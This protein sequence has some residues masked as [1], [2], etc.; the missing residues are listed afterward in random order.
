MVPGREVLLLPSL[1]YFPVTNMANS[2]TYSWIS[3]WFLV[4]APVIAWDVGF[5][6]MR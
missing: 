5:C 6:L 1:T 2:K 4:T 3:L